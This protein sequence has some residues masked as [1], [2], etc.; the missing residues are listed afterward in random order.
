MGTFLYSYQFARSEADGQRQSQLIWEFNRY[1]A[2]VIFAVQNESRYDTQNNL[3]LLKFAKY[4]K[5]A[6]SLSV[7]ITYLS[8]N[9]DTLLEKHLQLTQYQKL[10]KSETKL[11]TYEDLIRDDVE[12]QARHQFPN[13]TGHELY[14]HLKGSFVDF[15]NRYIKGLIGK[16]PLQEV[17][18]AKIF[19]PRT[20][21][22][23]LLPAISD[24]TERLDHNYAPEQVS[25]NTLVLK[26]HGS[27]N[28][29]KLRGALRPDVTNL[30]LGFDNVSN[31][32]ISICIKS[33]KILPQENRFSV[34]LKLIPL[35]SQ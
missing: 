25:P 9:Y 31:M 29:F 3:S 35:L 27:I 10:D 1:I 19:D 23:F 12:C 34:D 30:Y 33:C 11:G 16:P 4:L 14:N 15:N 18:P 20:G 5:I 2:D 13:Y 6:A 8:F 28:W 21:Y 32:Q 7:D 24:W 22:G 17:S 26:L